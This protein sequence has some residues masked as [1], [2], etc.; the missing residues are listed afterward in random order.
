MKLLHVAFLA[1]FVLAASPASSAT[2]T[3]TCRNSGVQVIVGNHECDG[4]TC[5][6]SGVVI[7]MGQSCLTKGNKVIGVCVARHCEGVPKYDHD[8]IKGYSSPLLP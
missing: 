6:N 2:D 7:W 4:G 8:G 3:T 1:S 5:W